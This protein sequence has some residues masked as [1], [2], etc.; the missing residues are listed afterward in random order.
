MTTRFSAIDQLN[1]GI[2][3]IKSGYDT[4]LKSDLV[5]PSCGVEDVDVS[6]FNLFDKEIQPMVGGQDS[7]E[8]KRVPVIFAAGEKWA[9]LKRGKPIRDRSNTL[10]LPLITI[11]RTSMSQEMD[12]IT[13]RGI[14]Q[15]T[16][17]IVVRRRLDKS[18]R[19]Y[20]NLINKTA[21]LFQKNVGVNPEDPQVDNQLLT[22]RKIGAGSESY[23]VLQGALL[24]TNTGNNVFET[25]VMPSPQFYT[26]TYQV[27]VWTQY[28]QHMNQIIEKIVSSFLPQGNSWKV[29]TEKGYWFIA[30]KQGGEFTI[31]SNFEDMSSAERYIK[32]NFDIKIP[33]YFWASNTP[34][35]PIPVKKYISSPIIQFTTSTTS[36]PDPSST[37]VEEFNNNFT[38]GNDDPTLPLSDK[39]NARPDQRRTGGTI[40]PNQGVVQTSNPN[41]APPLIDPQFVAQTQNSSGGAVATTSD[42]A[43]V[44]LPRGNSIPTYTRSK[45]PSYPNTY[46]IPGAPTQSSNPVIQVRLG[47]TVKYVKVTKVNPTTGETVYSTVNVVKKNPNKTTSGVSSS[48]ETQG[49]IQIIIANEEQ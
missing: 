34:G 48:S 39:P 3:G 35:T 38:V 17:E 26:A 5:I 13:G 1:N 32:C 47:N 33:A 6:L 31:D 22:G 23:N 2:P 40:T 11:M 12:D 21:I 37:D 30:T 36:T 20:Q 10:I 44:N 43:T 7:S 14:N 8:V 46:L 24:S 4:G 18:D 45:I 29:T 41:I 28:T 15:Q 49:G 27:T 16:G 9:L 42:P 19:Q 25:I